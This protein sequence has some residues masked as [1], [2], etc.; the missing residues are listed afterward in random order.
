MPLRNTVGRDP[1]ESDGGQYQPEHSN[2]TVGLNSEPRGGPAAIEI[3]AERLHME[4]VQIGIDGSDLISNTVQG[5]WSSDRSRIRPHHNGDA[6]GGR[7]HKIAGRQRQV[8]HGLVD[9]NSIL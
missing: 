8:N 5:I 7:P 6:I 9:T 3:L 4:E 1:G 2:A